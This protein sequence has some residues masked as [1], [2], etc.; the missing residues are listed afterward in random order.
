M[1][2]HFYTPTDL[3]ALC[4]SQKQK[5][6]ISASPVG[7]RQQWANISE[8]TQTLNVSDDPVHMLNTTGVHHKI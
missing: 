3:K 2:K 8:F 1:F 5:K 6:K 4:Y 7:C